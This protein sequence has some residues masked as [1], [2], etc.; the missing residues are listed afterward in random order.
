M[1]HEQA[2]ALALKL[3]GG[4]YSDF[5]LWLRD[6]RSQTG[7]DRAELIRRRQRMALTPTAKRRQAAIKAVKKSIIL[8]PAHQPGA[9]RGE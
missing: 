7:K 3:C 1:T 8:S 5:M 4:K 6:P 9:E 2:E